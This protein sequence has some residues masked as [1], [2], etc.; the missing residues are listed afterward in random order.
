VELATITS[1]SGSCT[2]TLDENAKAVFSPDS[3]KIGASSVQ[4]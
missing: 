3:R 1:S 2:A 4:I